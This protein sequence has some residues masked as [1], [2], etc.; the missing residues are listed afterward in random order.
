MSLLS[1]MLINKR[2][3]LKFAYIMRGLPSQVKGVGLRTLLKGL[4]VIFR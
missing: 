4:R 3:Y 2:V 1:I